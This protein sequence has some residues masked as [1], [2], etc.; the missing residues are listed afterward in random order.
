MLRQLARLGVRV[1]AAGSRA[2]AIAVYA[3]EGD[4]PLPAADRGFE[5]VACVDDAAR[6]LVLYCDLWERTGA[7]WVRAWAEGLLDFVLWMQEPDGR[8]VNFVLDRS[9]AKNRRGQTSEPGANFWQARGTRGLARA[10]LALG[11][12]RAADAFRRGLEHLRGPAASDQ[13]A[14]HALA[15][16]DVLRAGRWPELLALLAAWC[17]E[18]AASRDGDLLLNHREETEPHL[19]G[20]L[21]EGVLADAGR[22]LGRP[23]FVTVARRSAERLR[24]VVESGF[25]RPTVLPYEVACLVYD[26]ER[27]ALATGEA[28]YLDL[29]RKARAWFD[30][31]NTV[32]LPVYDRD[33]GRVADGIDDGRVSPRSG[34]EANIVG[35]QALLDEVVGRDW[36]EAEVRSPEPRGG[37]ASANGSLPRS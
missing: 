1:P 29:A 13:R 16:L 6:A 35:A 17:E 33:R 37:D 24:A 27:L 19:W 32:G 26:F 3:D 22:M 20:H 23:D 31:R 12:A 2:V 5:G 28:D 7:T 10:A 36:D 9:G 4:R 8:F 14:V 18:F 11:D 30:G 21:Q 15:L 25:G 34:A